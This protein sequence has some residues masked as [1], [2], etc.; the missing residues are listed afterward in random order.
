MVAAMTLPALVNS[1]QKRELKAS[2]EKNYS[3]AQQ[4]LQQMNFDNG[5]T[6]AG[7]AYQG[8]TFEAMYVK[9]F[10]V[11]KDCGLEACIPHSTVENDDGSSLSWHIANYKTYTRKRNVQTS[12]FDDGQFYLTDGS[13]YLIENPYLSEANST[14]KVYITIDVNGAAKNPNAW[15]H[16]LFT[17]QVMDNGQL[18][19][20]GAPDTDYIAEDYCNPNSS[21]GINGIGC[22]YYALTDDK[23]FKNLP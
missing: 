9:Y 5:I 22:A 3:V 19:P 15:G 18:K 11:L 20:M 12:M 17:F 10:N 7:S 21:S 8:R 13:L 4:A 16:D 14:Y 1:S 23:Y 2:L 6:I